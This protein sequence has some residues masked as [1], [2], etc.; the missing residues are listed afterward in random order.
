[1]R[2]IQEGD[3]VPSRQSLHIRAIFISDVVIIRRTSSPVRTVVSALHRLTDSAYMGGFVTERMQ[4]RRNLS[5]EVHPST[6]HYSGRKTP[7]QG[8]FSVKAVEHASMTLLQV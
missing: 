6:F 8:A 7:Q 3:E 5:M 4:K 2:V 1:M